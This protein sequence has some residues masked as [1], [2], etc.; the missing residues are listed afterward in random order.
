MF[1]TTDIFNYNTR[2][3]T[4][5]GIFRKDFNMNGVIYARFSSDHQ[6]EESIE[7]QIR[8]CTEYA[9][10]HGINIIQT[11]CDRAISGKT[12]K[13]PQF[14]KMIADSDTKLFQ[15]VIV[16]ALDRF[17]RN[18][19][20]SA[21]YENMLNLNG[22]QLH[23]ATENI[24]GS[25]SSIILKGVLQ[26]IAEYYSVELA[27]KITR[28][29]TENALKGKWTSGTTPFGYIRDES[30]HLQPH[31]VNSAYIPVI[32]D[33]FISGNKFIDIARHLNSLGLRTATGSLFN[34]GSFH[35]IL[36]NKVYIG[37][38]T[39][40]DVKLENAIPPLITEDVFYK[41][42]R[43]LEARKKMTNKVLPSDNFALS[44][45]IF[46]AHC[47]G[48]LIGMTGT[49]KTKAKH[50]YYVCSNKR[51]KK[52]DCDF[53]NI[54]KENVEGTLAKYLSLL[55]SDDKN[56]AD[57]AKYAVSAQNS[58][59]EN[60]E[61]IRLQ[62]QQ[63][64][65][66]KKIDN[67]VKVI[68][69]GFV[70]DA[71]IT[72]LKESEAAMAN[73]KRQLMEQTMLLHA[74]MLSEAQII[75]FLKKMAMSIEQDPDAV[76]RALVRAVYVEYKKDSDE[77]IITAH[78]NYCNTESMHAVEEFRVRNLSP[79]VDFTRQVTNFKLAFSQHFFQFQFKLPRRTQRPAM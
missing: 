60:A 28:G 25:P 63:K 45:R 20:Q 55:L 48:P 35:T 74:S 59:K 30:K 51:R 64:D 70:S 52:N 53:P 33:M 44:S 9:N 2:D 4:I 5:I 49:S 69:N 3:T 54:P 66:Q 47:D 56:L 36:T 29:M 17:A 40:K 34:K 72:R 78:F 58:A 31:P 77:Y 76:L 21:I 27:A 32:F 18:G 38:Y 42:Q 15:V 68:E 62:Q 13:R 19:K 11:Y 7:G 10:K 61:L 6:R 50:S 43:I 65:L 22:V 67:C 14:Q 75:F 12:D 23:S 57:I 1:G 26:S 8:I 37:E 79:V 73:L 46:C 39:W 24:T 71:I 16:Y 41:A